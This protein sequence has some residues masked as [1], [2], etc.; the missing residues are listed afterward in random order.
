METHGESKIEYIILIINYKYKN[1]ENHKI[2]F[3]FY[4]GRSYVCLYF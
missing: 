2:S 3:V 1:E 4:F